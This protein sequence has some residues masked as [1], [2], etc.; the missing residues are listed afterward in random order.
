[1]PR[2]TT[3][4]TTARRGA[5]ATKSRSRARDVAAQADEYVEVKGGDFPD[6]WDF[7]AEPELIGTFL[8]SKEISTKH[9][10][11]LLHT[12]EVDG[13]EVTAWGAAILNSRLEEID[14]GTDVKVVSTGNKIPTKRGKPATEYKVFAKRSALNPRR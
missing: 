10:P 3:S 4:K 6:A 12:F 9:G 1:M 2:A 5:T 7:D 13:V 8:G 11:R 14:P